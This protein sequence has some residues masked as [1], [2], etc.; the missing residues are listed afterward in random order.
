MSSNSF[1]FALLI[2]LAANASQNAQA[3]IDFNRD[4][5]PLLSDKC[6]HCHGPDNETLEADLRLDKQQDMFSERDGHKI[7]TPGDSSQ[8]ELVRR[9]RA[10]DVD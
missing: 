10:T 5:L 7:V 8:S 1:K 9:I 6:F 3:D 2:G 4:V